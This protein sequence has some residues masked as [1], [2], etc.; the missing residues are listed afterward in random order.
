MTMFKR[1]LATKAYD[2][3]KHNTGVLQGATDL[4]GPREVSLVKID[5]DMLVHS[6]VDHIYVNE[7]LPNLDLIL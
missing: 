7:N 2:Y 6:C 1:G 4:I 3:S 5:C